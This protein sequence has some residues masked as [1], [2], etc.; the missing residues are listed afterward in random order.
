MERRK[1]FLRAAI[2]A[3][4]SCAMAGLVA[5]APAPNRP[6]DPAGPAGPAGPGALNYVEGQVS[7]N[8]RAITPQMVG[9]EMLQPGQ[10]LSTGA[11]KAEILLTPGVFLRLG[12]NSQLRLTSSGLADIRLALLQGQATVEADYLVKDTNL[13]I[14][15][16]M[17]STRILNKG[18]YVVNAAQPWVQVLNGKAE[19]ALN[20]QQVKA[21]KGDEV[22]LNSS[23]KL[24][25]EGF[26]MQAAQ[27]EAL[28]RWSRLRSA[29]ESQANID[30]A[31]YVAENNG[32]WYGAGWYWDPAFG[33]WSYLPGDGILY[34]PWGFGFYS[35]FYAP[36]FVGGFYGGGFHRGYYGGGFH[37]G[38]HGGVRGGAAGV[39]GGFAGGGFRGSGGGFRG[40]GGGFHGGGGGGRR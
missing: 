30:T 12:D 5:A 14:D 6:A 24:K 9:S 13:T 11:G 16:G 37:G 25:R 39:H 28:V 22:T 40:G 35:P 8:G 2:I 10:V 36:V 29:Y 27:N 21:G 18:L 33:F 7:I 23:G 4:V 3:A 19:V 26:R 32:G 38:F 17:A 20:G 1:K 34:S 31:N 15:Q